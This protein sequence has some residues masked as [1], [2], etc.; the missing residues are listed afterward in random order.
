M[1][2]SGK[3]ELIPALEAIKSA[4]ITEIDTA[5]MY[6]TNEADL[7]AS[8]AAS[9]GF[10][11]STKNYG[12]WKKG[13]AL[14]P[15]ALLR[16]TEESLQKL[17][18]NQMDIFYIHGPDRTME[19]KEWVPTVQKIY[20]Q[21]KFRRFGVSNF[22][23]REVRDLW[24]YSKA[25]DYVL[26]TVYQGNYNA[27]SRHIEAT[28]FPTL[29]EL[30]IAFYAYSPVAGGFLTKSAK[31]LREGTEGGRFTVDPE[32]ETSLGTMYRNMY[33]KPT[34]LEALD[35]WG[36]LAQTQGVTNAELAYRWVY[37]HS[38]INPELGDHLI[39]GA[40][41]LGHIAPTVDGLKKGPLKP[42][43]AKGVDD[44]WSLIEADAIVNNFD[45]VKP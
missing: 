31:A 16:T 30:G 7:G 15:D 1:C 29:R 42:E 33:F 5:Q 3:D 38:H 41:R 21:G 39:L 20:E 13:E 6:G 14:Q 8:N 25:K 18:V 34:M 19:F 36:N 32:K 17:G 2:F 12:G 35:R 27:V 26:P 43:V 23:A 40:S 4:C 11:I 28:L 24:E 9:M 44:I 10:M 22:S 45:E 37:Y